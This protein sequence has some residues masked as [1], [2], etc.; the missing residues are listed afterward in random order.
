MLRQCQILYEVLPSGGQTHSIPQLILLPQPL[1]AP[2]LGLEVWELVK[3]HQ[4]EGPC[5]DGPIHGLLGEQSAVLKSQV[6]TEQLTITMTP[7]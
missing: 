1:D 7:S 3:T 5:F 2:V 4:L 6:G